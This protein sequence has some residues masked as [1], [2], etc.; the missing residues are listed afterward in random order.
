MRRTQPTL[1][2]VLV[3]MQQGGRV[4]KEVPWL[5]LKRYS[6]TV[7]YV[8]RDIADAL[9]N[10]MVLIW[11]HVVNVRRVYPTVPAFLHT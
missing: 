4:S 2:E 10:G 6:V 1:N 7:R 5:T 3:V 11:K 9:A 8:L